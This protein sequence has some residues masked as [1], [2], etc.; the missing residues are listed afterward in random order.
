MQHTQLLGNLRNNNRAMLEW[1]NKLATGQRIQRP[2][3]DPVGVGYQMRYDSEMNRN[4]EF[5]SN[6]STALGWLRTTDA[7]MQQATDVL[8]RARVLTQ[9]AANGTVPAEIRAQ[10]ASEI[11]QLREQM[12]S[13]GNSSYNGRF[14]FN[15]QK[16]DR[17]PYGGIDTAGTDTTD[18]GVYYLN[19]SA[20]VS[21]PVS[22]TGEQIFGPAG[23]PSNVFNILAGIEDHLLA[24]NQDELLSDLSRI[25]EAAD[26]IS[27]SWAEIGARTNR[28]ELIENR[29]QQEMQSLKTLRSEVADVDIAE[30][31]MQLKLKENVLQA[32]LATG[33]RIMQT[34]LVDFL[35]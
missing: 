29:I 17:P 10:I 32:S 8:K 21:V 14:V 28:F 3:D 7:L 9:Q 24:N 4:E 16:T 1:Q 2:G 20:L 34:S 35:R 27:V 18:P 30:A 11:R 26:R 33:A 15:G 13:I 12:V 6:V 25:D 5:L 19:V 23:D 22:I 31:I